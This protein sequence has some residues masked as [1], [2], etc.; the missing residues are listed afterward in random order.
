MILYI[1]FHVGYPKKSFPNH[2]PMIRWSVGEK[3]TSVSQNDRIVARFAAGDEAHLDRLAQPVTFSRSDESASIFPYQIRDRDNVVRFQGR[4][5]GTGNESSSGSSPSWF[6][7]KEVTVPPSNGDDGGIEYHVFPV[8]QNWVNFEK[9]AIDPSTLP[10]LEQTEK[11]MKDR[12][13]K[14]RTE[15]SEYLKQKSRKAQEAGISIF[16]KEPTGASDDIPTKKTR[17]LKFRRDAPESAV[18]FQKEDDQNEGQWEGDEAFS[19][20][21]DELFKDDVNDNEELDIDDEDIVTDDHKDAFDSEDEDQLIKDAFGDEISK[22]MHDTHEKEK[23]VDEQDLDDE[24]KKYGDE[25]GSLDED[26]SMTPEPVSSSSKPAPV[27]QQP[28]LIIARK[29]SK[30]DQIRARVKGMFWRNEYKLKLKDILAQF[31][32]LSRTSEEYQHLTK[33]LKDLAEVKDG[34]LHLKPQYRK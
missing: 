12:Q 4:P 24:L 34:V 25:M 6:A 30:E 10:D 7:V 9:V 17:K 8:S 3:T 19:D 11:M 29:T 18:S 32:G 20:D 1:F 28:P 2:L 16:P 31:P 5:V 15:Y 14:T 22:I 23:N 26:E 13:L 33:S 27:A 21:D